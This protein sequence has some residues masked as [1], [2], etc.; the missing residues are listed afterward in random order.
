MYTTYQ[1][2]HPVHKSR[3][4][5]RSS[6]Q[7]Q[8]ESAIQADLEYVSAQMTEDSVPDLP[9]AG[10]CCASAKASTGSD[11]P[12]AGRSRDSAE[13]KGAGGREMIG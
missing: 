4:F 2:D 7:P 13:A 6:D 5:V 1:I 12:A 8:T 10:L 3:D 11:V 9:L